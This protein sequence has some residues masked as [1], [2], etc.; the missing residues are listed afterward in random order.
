MEA[1]KKKLEANEEVN[2]S[3]R[4]YMKIPLSKEHSSHPVGENASMNQTVDKRIIERIYE[5][6]KKNVTAIKEVKRCL[7]EF[8]VKELFSGVPKSSWPRKTNR[9]YYPSSRDLRNHI[10]RAVAAEKYCNDD[11]ESLIRKIKDWKLFFFRTREGE[12]DCFGDTVPSTSCDN[13]LFV[14]QEEWQRKLL[15]K[16][17]S[18][19]VLL[20][21]TYKTTKY[22][23]PLFFLCVNTNVGYK[24]VAEFMC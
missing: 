9:R 2:T 1:L 7:E 10:A 6:A 22:A 20:D 15:L 5:L 12:P 16:F 23:I 14:H 11:Q 18:D 13:F 3:F 8:V 24:V 21:A 4:Y 19:L 17:G